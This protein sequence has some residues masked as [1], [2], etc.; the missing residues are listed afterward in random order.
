M[1]LEEIAEQL[2]YP[3]PIPDEWHPPK[4]P[5]LDEQLQNA[6]WLRRRK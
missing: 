2:N 6:D 1:T 5:N 3:L 4:I